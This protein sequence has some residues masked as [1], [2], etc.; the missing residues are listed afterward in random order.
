MPTLGGHHH[1]ANSR[2]TS[3]AAG[4]N[5]F[6][7]S[8][9][10]CW[11]NSLH[12]YSKP[13]GFLLARPANRT[14]SSPFHPWLYLFL[15]RQAIS[16]KLWAESASP[17]S[18]E[19]LYDPAACGLWTLTSASFSPAGFQTALALH[20]LP[21]V[22][23]RGQLPGST[24]TQARSLPP[25]SHG[26][27]LVRRLLAIGSCHVVADGATMLWRHP[28]W[29][30]VF[31]VPAGRFPG[32]RCLRAGHRRRWWMRSPLLARSSPPLFRVNSQGRHL[33][34]R[35]ACTRHADSRLLP[36]GERHLGVNLRKD[37]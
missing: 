32:A 6:N 8:S 17:G 19:L 15:I 10:G 7:N 5:V 20:S 2:V 21:A 16:M 34:A 3:D 25:T 12:L 23:P 22:A 28:S 29:W 27:L 11:P 26:L 37:L 24:P 9:F 1:P 35:P 30:R 33:R 31:R 4:V 13:G 36:A 14:P 18:I